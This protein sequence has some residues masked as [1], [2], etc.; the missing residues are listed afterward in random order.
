M[1]ERVAVKVL[2][3]VGDQAEVVADADDATEPVRYPAAEI[4]TAIGLPTE[5]LPGTRLTA[6]VDQSDR[7]S[8]WQIA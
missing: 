3:L 5:Q 8:G 2:L 4:A 7:L 1:S 6:E